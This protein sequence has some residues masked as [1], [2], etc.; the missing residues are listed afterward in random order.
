VEALH[1]AH[2]DHLFCGLNH[3]LEYL[4]GVP[5]NVLSDN[6]RQWVTKNSRY[7]FTFTDLA[8]QWSVF[9]KTNLEATRIYHPRDYVNKSIM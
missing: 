3:C 5:R 9:Y 6:M 8:V 1:S 4:G 2:A 7:E